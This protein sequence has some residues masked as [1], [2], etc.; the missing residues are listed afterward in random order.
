MSAFMRLAQADPIPDNRAWIDLDTASRRSGLSASHLSRR[1]QAEWAAQDNARLLS[2]PHGGKP[3]WFVAVDVDP[4]FAEK[5]AAA[6][7]AGDFDLNLLTDAQRSEFHRRLAIVTEFNDLCARAGGDFSR[8]QTLDSFLARL[9]AQ[10]RPVGQ[11]TLY[12]WLADFGH[13][14]RRGLIDRRWQT[15]QETVTAG[16]HDP[17]MDEMRRIF[18][19]QRRCSKSLCYGMARM[20]GEE[21]GW[22]IPSYSTACRVLAKISPQ[23][24]ALARLGPKKFAGNRGGYIE[25]DYSA[26]QS[27]D[28]WESDHY[29]FDVWVIGETGE[30]VRPWLTSWMDVRSRMLVGWQINS[31][32][33]N[34]R[35]ILAAF[36]AGGQAHDFPKKVHVDNGRDYDSYQL[37]GLTK[38]MKKRRQIADVLAGTWPLLGVEVHHALAY[39]AKAKTIERLHRTI[40]MRFCPLWETWCAN[41]P[42]NRPE[43]LPAHIKA[44]KAPTLD[45]FRQ[46]FTDWLAADYHACV[47]AGDGQNGRSPAQTFAEELVSKRAIPAPQLEIA[48]MYQTQPITVGRNGIGFG[49]LTWG[50]SNQSIIQAQG[51]QKFLRLDDRDLSTAQ[52][53]DLDGKFYCLAALNARLP[54]GQASREAL[55]QAQ[56]QIAQD[57]KVLRQAAQVRTRAG[58]TLIDRLHR[59]AAA[60]APA[61]PTAQ[62]PNLSLIQT[63]L[64]A[65]A[66]AVQK[67]Q[68]RQHMRIAVGAESMSPPLPRFTYTPRRDPDDEPQPIS[69]RDLAALRPEAES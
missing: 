51:R 66:S 17:F 24:A 49:G 67:A 26:L 65:A 4:A 20:L 54:Y 63:G 8:Q 47:H 59:R 33:G 52:V 9:D 35:T 56:R 41:S 69:F 61:A 50:R 36:I 34:S 12:R 23:A 58:D 62:Q 5:P 40:V 57:R 19:T 14:G 28:F 3:Q 16:P 13:H 2:P 22:T 11:R 31:H 29:Q 38:A 30:L 42:T 60:L 44:G 55:A 1:C 7:T 64:E 15:G 25:R 27:N 18:L 53:Y 21:R 6:A 32:A 48:R 45:E 10:G 37:N 39:N 43:D 46:A 68:E